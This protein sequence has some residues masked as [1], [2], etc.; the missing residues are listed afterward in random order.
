MNGDAPGIWWQG[1]GLLNSAMGEAVYTTKK[2]PSNRANCVPLRNAGR[3]WLS[4]FSEQDPRSHNLINTH[5]FFK[6][7][8]IN[9]FQTE[10]ERKKTQVGGGGPE[11]EG[12]ADPLMNRDPRR[13][14]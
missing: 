5:Y 2:Y 3:L 13:G 6:D 4:N 14:V 10:R 7:F 9:L 8:F 11:G 1:P 12:G